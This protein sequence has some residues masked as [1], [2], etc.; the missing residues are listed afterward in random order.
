VTSGQIS[1]VELRGSDG[2]VLQCQF[3]PA[4]VQI[5]KTSTWSGHPARASQKGPRQQ[6]VGTGPKTLKAKLLFDQWD[7]L[8]QQDPDLPVEKAVETMLGWM[9]ATPRSAGLAPQ[10]PTI[11]FNWGGPDGIYLD[12]FLHSVQAEYTM[13]SPRGIPLRAT[14]DIVLQEIT[15]DPPPTNPTSGGISGRRT[16]VLADCDTLAAIAYREYGDAAQWRGIAIANDV[17][18]PARLPPGT[19]LLLPPPA[20]AAELSQA[21]GG[22][23]GG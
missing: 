21:K 20:Q 16:A 22:P 1:R 11:T 14:A 13:F 2:T 19:R 15:N 18:D 6:F 9:S 3:N 8:G 5:S 4:T 23:G 10:P 7:E 17:Q 12:G